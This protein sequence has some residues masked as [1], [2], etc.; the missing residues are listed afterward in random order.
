MR[1]QVMVDCSLGGGITK[2]KI[3]QVGYFAHSMTFSQADCCCW[4]ASIG[5]R[6]RQLREAMAM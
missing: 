1:P 4:V 2:S 5:G 3:V 6:R